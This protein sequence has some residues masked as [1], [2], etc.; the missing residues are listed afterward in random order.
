MT[1]DRCDDH[2][3]WDEVGVLAMQ[4]HAI[5]ILD[6]YFPTFDA[7]AQAQ[8][9]YERAMREVNEGAPSLFDAFEA[10]RAGLA[11]RPQARVWR[12]FLSEAFDALAPFSFTIRFSRIGENPTNHRKGN[13][14]GQQ[15]GFQ[16]AGPD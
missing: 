4:E 14:H 6:R 5:D 8:E 10:V 1:F 2:Q 13:D 7:A 12:T 16:P 9:L 15:T 3:D 11:A